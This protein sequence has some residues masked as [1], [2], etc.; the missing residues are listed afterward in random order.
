MGSSRPLKH[1]LPP[2]NQEKSIGDCRFLPASSSSQDSN[3]WWLI[4]LGGILLLAAALR[5][6]GFGHSLWLDELHTAWCSSAPWDEVANRARQG[7]H[8]PLYFWLMWA[9]QQLLGPGEITLRWPSILS[10]SLLPVVLGILVR[11]L[12]GSPWA[13]LIAAFLT[14]CDRM[15]VEFSQEARPYS[16]LQLTLATQALVGWK[17][18]AAPTLA[19][20]AAWIGL[21]LLAFYLHYTASLVLAGEVVWLS[22]ATGWQWAHFRRN[23]DRASPPARSLHSLG[24]DVFLL[25]AGCLGAFGHLRAIAGARAQWDQVLPPATLNTMLWLFP[26][27]PLL[28]GLVGLYFLG[29]RRTGNHHREKPS[30]TLP[31]LGFLGC[32]FLVPWGLAWYAGATLPRYMLGA[33]TALP[34][35]GGC[36]TLWPRS[37]L[38]SFALALAIF[39]WQQWQDGLVPQY[40]RDG[41]FSGHGGEDWRGALAVISSRESNSGPWPIY[42]QPLL[43]EATQLADPKRAADPGLRNYLSYPL[44]TEIYPLRKRPTIPLSHGPALAR[45]T[46]DLQPLQQARKCWVLGRGSPQHR[47]RLEA[48]IRNDLGAKEPSLRWEQGQVP[49]MHWFLLELPPTPSSP[50]APPPSRLD[51][52][53][54]ER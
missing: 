4:S 14:A 36:L 20:R 48:W 6:W 44:Q 35:L 42:L 25:A 11:R 31:V 19:R 16:L 51:P 32:W 39:T 24:W 49:G 45:Q 46:V 27:T 41:T 40:L 28:G 34:A 5:A 3:R 13:G 15:F 38:T 2:K 50:S 1:P 17:L 12:T 37:R 26:L 47:T 30:P 29:R 52:P 21:G 53:A 9:N 18:L 54:S 33:A 8:S 7:N 23:P 10:G 43:I 22:A